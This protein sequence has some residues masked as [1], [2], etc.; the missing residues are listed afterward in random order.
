MRWY[1]AVMGDRPGLYNFHKDAEK[2]IRKHQTC[3]AKE[4]PDKDAAIKYYREHLGNPDPRFYLRYFLDTKKPFKQALGDWMRLK[5]GLTQHQQ[6]ATRVMAM[7]YE[8]VFNYLEEGLAADQVHDDPQIINLTYNQKLSIYQAM[9]KRS[10]KTPGE[11]I[12]AC[13]DKL[14]KAPFIN[15]HDFVD[16]FRTGGG[17]TVRH[18]WDFDDFCDYIDDGHK[19]DLTYAKDIEFLLPLLQNLAEG[20]RQNRRTGIVHH[21]SRQALERQRLELG[22]HELARARLS[23]TPQS[24]EGPPWYQWE[25]TQ[26][27]PSESDY[28]MGPPPESDCL[29]SD[30][31]PGAGPYTSSPVSVYARNSSP[32]TL[33]DA[34]STPT[35][36]PDSDF[37][38]S[39]TE[40]KEWD[41]TNVD[42][43]NLVL[44]DDEDLPTRPLQPRAMSGNTGGS[45][46]Q[47]AEG[48]VAQPMQSVTEPVAKTTATAV[49]YTLPTAVTESDVPRIQEVNRRVLSQLKL[50]ATLVVE[51][52]VRITRSTTRSATASN[53]KRASSPRVVIPAKRVCTTSPSRP[54]QVV[55]M[56]HTRVPGK[57]GQTDIRSFF[58]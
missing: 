10:G 2:Q 43:L 33:D 25:E 7:Q 40:R 49:Q 39:R 14:K 50:V 29:E 23:S 24:H 13:T 58:K 22:Q 42:V 44:D 35:E 32:P 36:K 28:M 12:P 8:I 5:N 31:M 26:S 48:N 18:F 56:Q 30:S 11:S 6:R 51:D 57:V 54:A 4:F 55:A 21:H 16:T 1:A 17:Q 41:W 3:Y 46:R 15:I 20:P 45:I 52:N 34:P 38:R 37:Q 19:F 47:S 53:Q 9:C 27:E